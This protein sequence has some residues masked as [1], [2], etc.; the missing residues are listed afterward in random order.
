MELTT[1]RKG[2]TNLAKP[3]VDETAVEPDGS[4]RR[5]R[6]RRGRMGG[7]VRSRR[8]LALALVAPTVAFMVLVHA[9]PS[10]GGVF[11]SFK[12]LNTF[13]FLQLFGAPWAGLDNYTRLLFDDAN[14]LHNGFVQAVRN[15]AFYA[16]LTVGGT[17]AGGLGLAL[18]L[19]RPFPGQRV[20]RTLMLAPWVV[21]SFV[22]AILWQVMWQQDAGVINR[23]LVDWLGLLDARPTWLLGGNTMW[24]IVIPTIWR[25]LPFAMLIFLAGL[26]AVPPELLEAASMDGAGPWRRFWH[27]T[28]PLIRPLFAIQLLFGVVYNAYQFTIPVVM[29]GDNPGADADL[30]M[31][32]V[33]RQSFSGRQVGFGSAASTLVTLAMLVWVAVWYRMFRRDLEAQR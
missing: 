15:T 4:P 7:L 13:T 30:L 23:I 22:V 12:N 14:P 32:L 21:P 31:T 2:R 25:G 3:G 16:V 10:G 18:L 24:A 27:V 5:R 8:R 29:L 9:I 19:N 33:I 26:Q 1:I 11:L 17:L 6:S 20:V 28:F